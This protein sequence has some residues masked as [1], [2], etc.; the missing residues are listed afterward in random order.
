[1]RETRPRTR[2]L[3]VLTAASLSAVLA[4]APS[5]AASAAPDDNWWF[6]AYGMAA[7]HDD[8]WT[9][10][11]VTVAV[12]DANINPELP[13]FDDRK[14]VVDPRPLCAEASSPT[15]TEPTEDAIHGT[16]VVAQIIGSGTGPDGTRGIAPDA[17]VTFYSFGT[18]SP[19]DQ[20]TPA[21]HAG[22]LTPL[23][24]GV[25]RAIEDG[26][27]VIVSSIAGGTSSFDSDVIA[28]AIAKGVLVIGSGPNPQ[29]MFSTGLREY[30]GVIVASAVNDEGQLPSVDGAPFVFRGTTVVA[31]GESL[32]TVGNAGDGWE[33]GGVA[34]GSSFAAPIVAGMLALAKQRYPTATPA[35]LVQGLV[36]N[37]G[38]KAHELVN[39]TASG[40]GYGLAWP[41]RLLATDPATYPD[42][43]LL[44]G[45]GRSVPTDE[46]LRAAA[47]RGSSFPPARTPTLDSSDPPRPRDGGAAAPQV[48]P[49]A[50]LILS[51]VAMTVGLLVAV[52][53]IITIV[54]VLTSRRERRK[55]ADDRSV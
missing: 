17:A 25:Q 21:E 42:E 51:V 15:T 2:W 28:N 54:L 46:Q 13:V 30:R 40:F 44:L 49:S 48:T 47:A 36:R 33:T 8:G 14:L 1:M 10:A 12:I 3:R 24:L 50:H 37:T 34:S 43:N 41:A 55:G 9:G 16:T 4:I 52:G 6:D 31:P 45:N 18:E 32:G 22:K 7:I 19:S 11:G 39:D 53:A 38:N 5:H 26:A 23:G 29:T 20:C 35:Q 27:D